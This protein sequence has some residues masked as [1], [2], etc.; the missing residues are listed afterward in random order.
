MTRQ[1]AVNPS[2]EHTV[3]T[4]QDLGFGAAVKEC[5]HLFGIGGESPLATSGGWTRMAEQVGLAGTRDARYDAQLRM[6][7]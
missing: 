2:R 1:E 5:M 4:L 3:Q 6:T 7:P